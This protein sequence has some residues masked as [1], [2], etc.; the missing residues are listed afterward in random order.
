MKPGCETNQRGRIFI[1]H[2]LERLG[3]GYAMGLSRFCL[4]GPVSYHFHGYGPGGAADLVSSC[5]IVGIFL[6]HIVRSSYEGMQESCTHLAFREKNSTINVYYCC[7]FIGLSK[8]WGRLTGPSKQKRK[9][10]IA[11]PQPIPYN[12]KST[13]YP[14]AQV[15]FTARLTYPNF[16]SKKINPII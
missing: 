8:S 5:L 16:C 11:L 1:N 13:K 2:E 3:C 12:L 9:S 4:Q 15:C 7:T 10:P 14:P 6:F